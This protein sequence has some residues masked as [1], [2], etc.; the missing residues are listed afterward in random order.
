MR[1]RAWLAALAAVLVLFGP[2]C[3]GANG[4]AAPSPSDDTGIATTL[5]DFSIKPAE[6]ETTAGSV[7]F[8]LQ[9]DGPSDHTFFV[10]RTDLADDALPVKDHLVELDGL[11]VVGQVDDVPFDATPSLTVSLTPGAYVFLCNYPGHYESGMYAAFTV[12]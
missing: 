12:T 11:D 8:D 6:K 1:R 5:A 4:E 3:G 2:A 10:V 7:T 9:N